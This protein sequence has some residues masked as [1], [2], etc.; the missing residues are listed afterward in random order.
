MQV[1]VAIYRWKSTARREDIE[2]ALDKVKRVRNNVSGILGIYV[3]E[4]TSRYGEG[5]TH[6]IVVIGEDQAA[7][8]AY[9]ADS[10]H[11]EAAKEI[12]FFEDHGVG[13]DFADRS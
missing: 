6:A 11:E 12:E 4:N 9:R 1:H 8:D 10:L 7:L 13:I 5:F 2:A 3:G